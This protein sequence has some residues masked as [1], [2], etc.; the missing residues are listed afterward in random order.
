VGGMTTTTA[1]P[2]AI[3]RAYIE[4]VGEGRFDDVSALLHPDLTFRMNNGRDTDT[5][6]D[7]V[8]A[9]R[10]LFTVLDH[11]EVKHVVAD[12]DTVCIGYDFVTDTPVG[13]VA[14]AEWLTV[15][16][17]RIRTIRL[18]FQRERWPEVI[19][20]LERRQAATAAT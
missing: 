11:N 16:D 4:A 12:H 8:A 13:A 9:L 3:A 20:E 18:A 2:A 14:T 7:Y 5:R 19:Q 1:D 6:D 15:E 17:G 10:R